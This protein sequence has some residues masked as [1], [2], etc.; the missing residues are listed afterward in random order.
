MHAQRLCLIKG[1]NR[2]LEP[3]DQVLRRDWLSMGGWPPVCPRGAQGAGGMGIARRFQPQGRKI[4]DI[5][6]HH[7]FGGGHHMRDV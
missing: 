6:M 7:I 2:V 5:G 1:G 4:A 3:G